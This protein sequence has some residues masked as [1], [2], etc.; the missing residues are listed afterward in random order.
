MCADA[1]ARNTLHPRGCGVCEPKFLGGGER[2]RV[3]GSLKLSPALREGSI[4]D[5][6][7][8]AAHKRREAER[9]K[10]KHAAACVGYELGPQAKASPLP[11]P[12]A[13]IVP[14]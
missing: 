13:E 14:K 12:Y 1:S 10:Q 9:E 6:Y 11:R 4:L 7:R 3:G 5:G 2:S 8:R